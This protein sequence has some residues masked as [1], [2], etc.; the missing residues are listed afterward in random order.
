[1]VKAGER[2]GIDWLIYN[3]LEFYRYH[4]YAASTCDAVADALIETFPHASVFSDIGAGTGTY[5]A[6]LQRRQK[7]AL[8]CERSPFGRMFSRMQRVSSS[9][10]DLR[11]D[12]PA[13]FQI[14][15]VVYCFEVAEH[16][17][18]ELGDRLAAFIAKTAHHSAMIRARMRPGSPDPGMVVFS[19]AHPG[20]GGL[21]HINEQPKDYWIERFTAYGLL[22]DRKRSNRLV[23]A[24]RE[25]GAPWW[26]VDNAI[27]FTTR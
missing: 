11:Q 18:P 16:L 22:T 9:K 8:A 6:A 17:P 21:A 27:V 23:A 14:A 20:Q 25:H 4:Q 1:M 24:F 2:H 12:Q 3:P 10:F 7:T 26:L 19:A 5:A 15:D 13:P